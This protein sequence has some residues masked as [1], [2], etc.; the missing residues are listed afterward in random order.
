FLDLGLPDSHGLD[1]LSKFLDEVTET[2]VIVLTTLSDIHTGVRALQLGA[3]DYL[4][5]GDFDSSLLERVILYALQ[6]QQHLAEL[7]RRNEEIQKSLQE[8]ELLLREVHH[9][10]KNNLQVISSLLRLQAESSK[11][12][13]SR[14]HLLASERRVR[15]MALVHERMYQ[16]LQISGIDFSAYIKEMGTQLARTLV[17]DSRHSIVVD[18]E[19]I[20][21]SVDKAIPCGLI[22]NE[23]VG[24]ALK[25][26]FS[27]HQSGCIFISLRSQDE[28]ISLS[29]ADNGKG[30]PENFDPSSEQT[31]GFEI[32][33]SLV[34]QLKGEL[35]I[36][37]EA[38]TKFT[39]S[40]SVEAGDK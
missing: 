29:V 37:A 22:F 1:T 5:K 35:R 9:R 32:I 18:A 12:A 34:T 7:Q 25:H 16:D 40:F 4:V 23:L 17:P 14:E 31:L 6:R 19:Q 3:Q 33:S 30:L 21:L 2:P 39:L 13:E 10:V 24:N 36:E 8:K 38:G 20:S 27:G 15:S 11:Q 26:A 28:R